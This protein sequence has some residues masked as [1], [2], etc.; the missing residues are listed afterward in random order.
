MSLTLVPARRVT[1]FADAG[2]KKTLLERFVKLGAKGYSVMECEGQG[3]HA[4]I[5]DP[6]SG[7]SRVCIVTLVQ[8]D[9]AEKIMEYL[10][11]D[12]F[13]PYAVTSCVDHIEVHPA[14][15]F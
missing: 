1:V 3:E 8:P 4:V 6:Y 12:E 5:E 7:A 14:D 2:L 9:V 15:R 10:H 11:R 13:V